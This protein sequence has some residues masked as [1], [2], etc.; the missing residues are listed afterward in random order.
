MSDERP[1][2]AV[3]GTPSDGLAGFEGWTKDQEIPCCQACGES[4]AFRKWVGDTIAFLRAGPIACVSQGNLL[5]D[6]R[7][8]ESAIKSDERL[9]DG[10]C[11]NGCARMIRYEKGD[12]HTQTCPVCK[13]VGWQNTPIDF[14]YET[15]NPK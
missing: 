6:R 1:S 3:C 12:D 7:E 8:L 10:I 15:S 4:D 9:A 2:C 13:F 11:P 14:V 5:K